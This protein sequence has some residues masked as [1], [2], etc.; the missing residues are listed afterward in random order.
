[1]VEEAI[2]SS[3]FN[4]TQVFSG[5]RTGPDIFGYRWAVT[6]KIPLRVF[7][8]EWDKL[9]KPAD[10]IKCFEMAAYSDAAIVLTDGSDHVA[11]YQIRIAKACGCKLFVVRVERQ[12]TTL[13]D[14][15]RVQSHT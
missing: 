4:I 6:Q 3:T 1:M 13:A 9:G 5:M 10:L 14:Y 15:G 7:K 12:Q 2:R 11:E 8:P